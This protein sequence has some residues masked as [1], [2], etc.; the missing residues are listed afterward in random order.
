[1]KLLQFLLR[2]S[3]NIAI[4]IKTNQHTMQSDH[5][6]GDNKLTDTIKYNSPSGYKIYFIY[7]HTCIQIDIM[8][9]SE[10]LE[11]RHFV[12]TGKSYSQT[13]FTFRDKYLLI[14]RAYRYIRRS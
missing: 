1:M 6:L 12:C 5:L 14:I 2:Y 7:V 8:F 3:T 9:L 10:F 11:F 13:L 4:L